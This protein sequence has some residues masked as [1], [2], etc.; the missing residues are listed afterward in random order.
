[1]LPCFLSVEFF[2]SINSPLSRFIWNNKKP[3]ISLKTLMKPE[4]MGGLGLPNLQYY[5]WAAQLRN[6]TSWAMERHESMWVQMEAKPFEPLP[7]ISLLFINHF[8]KMKNMDKCFSVFNTL[9]TW[10]DCRKK[11]GIM[12]CTSVYSPIFQ[13][14]DLHTQITMVNTGQW[15]SSGVT[16]FKDLL[17]SNMQ[18]KSFIDLRSEYNIPNKQFFKYL[19]I[20]ST[21]HSL[22]K[23]RKLRLGLSEVEDNLLSSKTIKGKISTFYN[24]LSR[25]GQSSF[26]LLKNIWEKE[27]GR[28]LEDNAWL[29]IC[30]R[31]HFPFTSNKIKE[32]NFKFI[33]KYYLTPIKMHKISKDISS[34][35]PRCKKMEGTFMHMFWECDLL[36]SYWNS[37]HSLAQLVLNIKFELNM[38]LYLLNDTY[39]LQLDNKK[40]RI[41]VLVTYFAKKCILLFWKNDSPPSF[42]IFLDQLSAFLPLEKLTLEKYNRGHL[43]QEFWSPLFSCLEKC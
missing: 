37:I 27:L 2:K 16:Q 42:K 4:S 3:R 38:S 25:E 22:I 30:E 10:R 41:L 31:I 43:F 14:P 6:M 15:T 7:L 28:N 1:M 26:L 20:R 39:D 23:E 19:Q 9:K 24:I 12:S 32:A 34:K 13:N 40:C 18:L 5:F 33:H 36:K 21:T 8:E 29:N 17:N 11:S 35:C